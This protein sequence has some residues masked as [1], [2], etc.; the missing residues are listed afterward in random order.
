[1]QGIGQYHRLKVVRESDFGLYLSFEDGEVLLPNR[2]TEGIKPGDEVEVFLYK[3]SED[4]PVATTEKPL[5]TLGEYA[6]MEVV[7]SAPFGIFVDMGLE[8]HL[9]VP[10]S[11]MV[12]DMTEGRKYLI[13]V[14]LDYRTERLIGVAKIDAFSSVPEDLQSG[15]KVDGIVYQK[16]DLG[17]KVWANQRFTGLLYHNRIFTPLN[18]GD[19][20][21][22]YVDMI[23]DDG[24][25]DL[26]LSE[27]GLSGIETDGQKIIEFLKN[28]GGTMPI[29][30][31]SSPNEIQQVFGMSK[32]AFKRAIGNL[33]KRNLLQ[34][35][36]HSIS[37]NQ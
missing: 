18:I 32:K 1:M 11:E 8:K 24:K 10:K 13:R 26:K 25:V 4:R 21:I 36:D 27:G 12:A 31:K 30:D 16:S 33:Y 28:N 35:G 9:L 7:G 3:D 20:V 17:F 22:C 19:V 6:M 23:R 34:L 37:L 15:E 29:T 14:M 2:Y 5:A